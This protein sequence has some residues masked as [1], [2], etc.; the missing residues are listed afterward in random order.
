MK[1]IILSAFA[2]EY[3][4]DF[5][6]QIAALRELGIGQIEPRFIGDRGILELSCEEL[7]ELRSKLDKAGIGVSSIGSPIGKISVDG[8]FDAHLEQAKRACIAA[9]ILGAKRIRMFSFYIPE[10]KTREEC[11]DE[12]IR[13]LGALLDLADEYGVTL[14]HENEAKIYG[15]SPEQC[16]DLLCAFGGR[17]RCV[18]DMGNFVLGNYKPYPDGYKLLRDYIEYFHIKDSLAAGAIVPPGLGEAH[19]ADILALHLEAVPEF[20]VT[21]E[22]HLE[23]FGGLNRLTD[24]T[25]DNPYKFESP[26]AAFTEAA[27]R[28]KVII[29]DAVAR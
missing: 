11:R 8:D 2:D 20:T 1:N 4:K 22:P 13:R 14:C 17:L 24:V 3:T 28:I 6:G 19:I 15:E 25:F 12:V 26:E 27:D 5:D 18:F 16:Y 29:K 9:N 10:G 23:T 21:L 7:Y